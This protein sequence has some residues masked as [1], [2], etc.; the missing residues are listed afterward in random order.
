MRRCPIYKWDDIPPEKSMFTK[1]D[2]IGGA[3]G[4]LIWQN[5]M[6]FYLNDI[7]HLVVEQWGL[8]YV[9]FVDDIAIVTDNKECALAMIPELRRRLADMGCELHPKK[10]YCQH[11]TKGVEFIGATIK[12]DRVYVNKRV[13]RNAFRSVRQ[14]NRCV[15]ISKLES[16][17]SSMNSYLG[18]FKTRNGYAIARN[19]IDTVNPKWWKYCHFNKERVCI[20]PNDG[21]HPTELLM[22]KYH[23]KIKKYGR[24]QKKNQRSRVAD[25]GVSRDH[26]KVG[27]KSG[28]VLEAQPAFC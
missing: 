9:R 26:G 19:L 24:N 2:G 25:I 22:R 23:F 5:A 6:N 28:Q 12:M 15:R 16:F 3:I 13:I 17:I 20:Q 8:H 21:Y 11:Y 14:F 7:D 18:I 1:P 4:Y 27:R 10:F